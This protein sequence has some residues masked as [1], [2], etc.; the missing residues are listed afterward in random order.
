MS[1][2]ID[3]LDK[4]GSDAAFRKAYAQNPKKT[5]EDFGLTDE[6]Q[7]AIMNSD[8]EKVKKIAGLEEDVVVFLGI[9][10]P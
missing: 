2:L 6:E 9:L 3:F 4:L 7:E 10:M 8:V 5:M 1:K